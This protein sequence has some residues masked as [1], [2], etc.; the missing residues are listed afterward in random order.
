MINKRNY[1]LAGIVALV[2][3]GAGAWW[4]RHRPAPVPTTPPPAAEVPAPPADS[5]PAVKYP[6]N[7]P[8]APPPSAPADVAGALSEMFGPKTVLSMF[9]TDDLARR[10][11]ATVDNL[12]LSYAPTALWPVNPA[13]G[14]FVTEHSGAT[15]IIGGG[16]GA[17]YTPYVLLLE[18][19]NL[20]RTVQLYS[21]LYPLF[22][23]A[24]ENLGY[25]Q[26][27]F[28][29]RLVE[30]IDQL[31]ATPEVSEPPKVHLPPIDESVQPARPW[32]LYD[33]N[34]PALQS[35]TSGQK[36]LLRMGLDNEQRVKTRLAEIRRLV[37]TAVRQ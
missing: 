12:G 5:A 27:Y 1:A 30:V 15:E 9:R 6:I 18:S 21:H 32:V 4:W 28:N 26:R 23:K 37:T 34:E 2:L 22:Q 14:R 16:N 25:P 3:I 13:G 11:V 20:P 36:I 19:V 7:T 35:L 24:Y 17:R 31:L 29:D 33:F 8:T 10:F